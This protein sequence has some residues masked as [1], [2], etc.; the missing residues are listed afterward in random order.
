M[1]SLLQSLWDKRVF[2][3]VDHAFLGM[4]LAVC[5]RFAPLN[6]EI[7]WHRAGGV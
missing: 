5:C 4:L 2:V 1:A 7:R 3:D 6:V